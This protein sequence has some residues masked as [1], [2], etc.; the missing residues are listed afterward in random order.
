MTVEC[1]EVQSTDS[2]QPILFFIGFAIISWFA[3]NC[4][5]KSFLGLRIF[6]V[7]AAFDGL[8]LLYAKVH[9]IA[10]PK[11]SYIYLAASLGLILSLTLFE[12]ELLVLLIL[13]TSGLL[14]LYWLPMIFGKCHDTTLEPSALF[15]CGR[16]C[17]FV[18]LLF[19]K[20]TFSQLMKPF[21]GNSILRRLLLGLLASIPILAIAIGLLQQVDYEF[22]G[23]MQDFEEFMEQVFN[24]VPRFA[25]SLLMGFYLLSMMLGSGSDK[26]EI[27][28]LKK[29]KNID[30]VI[31]SV[32]I[33]LL[34]GL[35][36]LFITTQIGTVVDAFDAGKLA[37]TF[38][39]SFARRGFA[40]LCLVALLNFSVAAFIQ[41]RG[42]K[43]PLVTKILLSLL[44]FLTLCL[45]ALAFSKMYLYIAIFSFTL[46]RI[47]TCCFM[48]VLAIIF[49]LLIIAQWKELPL[50]KLSGILLTM[51]LLVLSYSNMSSF[52]AHSNIDNY[53]SG[54]DTNLPYYTES[55]FPS[56]A[57]PSYST[58]FDSVE[59]EEEQRFIY[60]NLKWK[61]TFDAD[62]GEPTI[63]NHSLQAVEGYHI[64]VE[65]MRTH[66]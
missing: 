63:W 23:S 43:K 41:R 34:C 12:N 35:Y 9:S 10:V 19:G 33:V 61:A 37:P 26:N 58:A 6:L 3:I 11:R 49:V 16:T 39:S 15:D 56:A 64:A 40:E 62:Q 5:L 32:V 18:P 52:V 36:S 8:C 46:K 42:I 53:L 27:T 31:G 13:I 17:L 48:L 59:D 66:P 65:F 2:R 1:T 4:L 50:F 44:G 29:R 51:S 25:L 20:E 57:V 55:E 45:I 54:K 21:K 30:T 24:F 38:Y 47:Y 7:F 14:T 22:L 60:D 28:S